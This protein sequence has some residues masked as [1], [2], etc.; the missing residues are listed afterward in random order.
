MVVF[1]HMDTL[2]AAVPIKTLDVKAEYGPKATPLI[3]NDL[4]TVAN[5]GETAVISIQASA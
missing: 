1:V 4:D 5:E 3:E 2:A